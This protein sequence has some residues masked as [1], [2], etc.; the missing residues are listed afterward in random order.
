[1][2]ITVAGT[3]SGI[4]RETVQRM[5]KAFFTTKEG[6]GLG[7]WIVSELLDKHDGKLYVSSRTHPDHHGPS[8][9]FSCLMRSD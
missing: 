1:V 4:S 7:V 5:R 3:G 6:T 8:H 9:H 2:R